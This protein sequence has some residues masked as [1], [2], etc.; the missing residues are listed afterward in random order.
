MS[1]P[2]TLDFSLRQ[3]EFLLEI[4][5]RIE[6]RVVALFGPSGAGKTS[7][8]ESIAGL[9]TPEQGVIQIGTRT[10]FDTSSGVDLSAHERRVGYVPQDLALFP[11]MNVRR[12]I[13][14][15]ADAGGGQ[16]LQQV[17]GLLEIDLLLDREVTALSGGE[18][19]RVALARALMAG[20][21]L[22]L[23]DEPLAAL[24]LGLRERILPYLERV[25]DELGISMLYVSHAEAEVRA[26]ADWVVVLDAGRV[27]RSG[28]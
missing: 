8:L 22:L 26:I 7:V 10:L 13:L 23:L 17:G 3:G 9:R 25:R 20:P 28:S 24:D 5:E 4:H 18:R 21:A 14:Y 27:V 19:Q 15:G 11:H 12:N 2:I 6:A 16:L 1:I